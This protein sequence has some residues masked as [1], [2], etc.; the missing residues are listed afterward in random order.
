M[1]EFPYPK[2][3]GKEGGRTKEEG[4]TTEGWKLE[5][6]RLEE[7]RRKE[8]R[9]EGGREEGTILLHLPAPFVNTGKVR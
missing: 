4:G 5:E 8:G 6:T 2:I 9:K 1:V 7:G 3:T